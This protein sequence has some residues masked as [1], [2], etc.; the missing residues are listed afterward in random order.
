MKHPTNEH[1]FVTCHPYAVCLGTVV[2]LFVSATALADNLLVNSDFDQSKPGQ[3]NFG[4]T[5][6]LAKG[7]QSHCRTV[8]GRR[9]ESLALQIYNDQLGGSFVSQSIAV[10]PWRWYVAEVWV[11][12]DR[13]YSPDVRLS[14]KNGRK[15]GQWQ[16]VMDHFDKPPSGWRVIRAYDHTASS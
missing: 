7:Q 16:Y 15:R 9:S 3:E 12:S 11:K 13:M 6:E 1:N 4:W 10:R 8:P 5:L 2:A 14:L